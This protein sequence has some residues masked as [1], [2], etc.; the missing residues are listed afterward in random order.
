MIMI[1][2]RALSIISMTDDKGGT[3]ALFLLFLLS[4]VYSMVGHIFKTC[5]YVCMYVGIFMHPYTARLK[6]GSAFQWDATSLWKL[7]ASDY[8]APNASAPYT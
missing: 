6:H 4:S 5:V 1:M 2:I 7:H 3:R 8:P